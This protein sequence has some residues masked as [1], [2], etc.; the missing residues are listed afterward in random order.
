MAFCTNCGKA[1]GSGVNFCPGCGTRVAAAPAEVKPRGY[2]ETMFKGVEQRLKTTL[3]GQARSATEKILSK[4]AGEARRQ[5]E[6]A[7]NRSMNSATSG[8]SSSGTAK[9]PYSDTGQEIRESFGGKSGN[10][11]RAHPGNTSGE[12]SR[13]SQPVTPKEV[14]PETQGKGV[15]GW[16]WIFLLLSILLGIAGFISYGNIEAWAYGIGR[17]LALSVVILIGVLFRRNKAKPLNWL[18]KI[19]LLAQMLFLAWI[20]YNRVMGQYFD[21]SALV[22][23][24]LLST[25]LK[26]LFNGNKK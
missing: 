5:A 13:K 25:D 19:L 22:M 11:G 14:L 10:T 1:L 15:S 12:T 2:K 18:V 16:I 6:T 21:L 4:A 17:V 7:F 8:S 23:T 20:L 9:S 26:L 3:Q 24:A